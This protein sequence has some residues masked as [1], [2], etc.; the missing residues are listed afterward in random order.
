MPR[1]GLEVVEVGPVRADDLCEGAAIAD[2]DPV[3]VPGEGADDEGFD[4]E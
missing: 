3:V 1:E 2:R 4:T